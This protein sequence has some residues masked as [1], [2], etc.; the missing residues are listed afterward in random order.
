MALDR[1]LAWT[2][3]EAGVLAPP[4]PLR[5]APRTS[6][7]LL[8]LALL[9]LV[10][11]DILV[12]AR[13]AVAAWGGFICLVTLVVL[14]YR[15]SRRAGDNPWVS[16]M[17]VYMLYIFA[18]QYG[19]GLLFLTHY[20]LALEYTG[21]DPLGFADLQVGVPRA[22]WLI[23]IGAFG[24]YAG[25]SLP[26]QGITRNLPALR[27]TEDKQRFPLRAL[28]AFPLVFGAY[29]YSVSEKALSDIQQTAYIMGTFGMILMV[30]GFVRLLRGA[31]Q[32]NV[33]KVVVGALLLGYVG[34]G[35]AFGIRS[36]WVYM[37]VFFMWSVIAVKGKAPWKMLAASSVALILFAWIVFPW[38][39]TYKYYRLCCAM[40]VSEAS[41][42]AFQ[43]YG[44]LNE[45][46]TAPGAIEF[47]RANTF[48]ATY[49]SSYQRITPEPYPYLWGESALV[50]LSG[51]VPRVVNPAKQN[52]SEYVQQL[53]YQAGLYTEATY[54]QEGRGAIAIDYVSEFYLNFGPWGVLLLSIL[55]GV[56]LR[57][58][59]DWLIRRSNFDF[60]FPMY[61]V[62]FLSSSA[63]WQTFVLDVKNWFIWGILLWVVSRRARR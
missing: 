44:E 29:L 53:A 14:G 43:E 45:A 40:P 60:G 26:L 47:L 8:F 33:W 10:F 2:R 31:S 42:L 12:G 51:V 7:T 36:V 55:Q 48:P 57:I 27:W 25:L 38:L 21:W 18:G 49:V 37:V 17:F 52:V 30:C 13:S 56:Y 28:F 20:D 58:R 34:V 32:P 6:A 50:V 19:A 54:Y 4:C 15:Q 23:L 35:F 24:T 9:L 63:L 22:A 5:A 16:P 59:Y 11:P 3:A 1:T 62:G 41:K 61:A 46:L 39:S